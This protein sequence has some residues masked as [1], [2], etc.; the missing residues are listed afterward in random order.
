MKRQK[1][2]HNAKRV[3]VWDNSTLVGK[4]QLW[5]AISTSSVD[6]TSHL[7]NFAGH[8][9]TTVHGQTNSAYEQTVPKDL[10]AAYGFTVGRRCE[11]RNPADIREYV[12]TIYRLRKKGVICRPWHQIG[13]GQLDMGDHSRHVTVATYNWIRQTKSAGLTAK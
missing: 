4:V 1:R 9:D 6:K 5:A 3:P 12:N 7:R 10:G 8:T 13:N 2:C 11:W